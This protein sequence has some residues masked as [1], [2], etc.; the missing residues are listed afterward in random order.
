MI[1]A[2]FSNSPFFSIRAA[3]RAG[4]LPAKARG[5]RALG[6]SSQTSTNCIL[7]RILHLQYKLFCDKQVDNGAFIQKEAIKIAVPI[8]PLLARF[9]SLA[10][11]LA[12]SC[13]D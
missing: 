11:F 1:A 5:C 7:L 4:V 2:R 12:F 8:P 6:V 3:H 13:H 10:S 9:H